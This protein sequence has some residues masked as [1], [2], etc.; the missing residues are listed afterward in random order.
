MGRSY[1]VRLLSSQYFINA[2]S[3]STPQPLPRPPAGTHRTRVPTTTLALPALHAAPRPHSR[4]G[5][6][7]RTRHHLLALDVHR[8]PPHRRA[9]LVRDL[10]A[11][12]RAVARDSG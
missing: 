4:H 9:R 5:R 10:A 12:R 11:V 3:L 1:R 7:R 6:L 2:V 8:P